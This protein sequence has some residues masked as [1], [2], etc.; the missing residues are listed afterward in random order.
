[1]RMIQMMIMS[2]VMKMIK[3]FFSFCSIKVFSSSDSFFFRRFK[4]FDSI[5]NITENKFVIILS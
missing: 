3:I 1:M 4:F 2:Q 5:Y